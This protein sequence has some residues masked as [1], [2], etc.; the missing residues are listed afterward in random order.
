MRI[1]LAI[2]L[3]GTTIL[4]VLGCT[5]ENSNDQNQ[6]P[7]VGGTGQ[8]GAGAAMSGGGNAG[9]GNASSGSAGV[10]AEGGTA[11]SATGGQSTG[12]SNAGT[13]GNT[14]GNAGSAAGGAA[15]IGGAGTGGMSSCLELELTNF[16]GF[17][18][19][20]IR[21]DISPSLGADSADYFLI[22]LVDGMTGS[23]NLT[24]GDDVNYKTCSH[25]F[26]VFQDVDNA[27]SPSKRF[28]QIS[29]TTEITVADPDLNATSAGSI[30]DLTLIEVT[31]TGGG[32][33]TSTPVEGGSCL[34]VTMGMWDTTQLAL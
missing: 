21:A 6:A 1:I 3:L 4:T 30:N 15:G 19:G 18:D 16:Q 5:D 26:S 8:A 22:E 12:G 11:G 2:T 25:C 14:G 9:T 24:E 10:S 34:H 28:F 17:S 31:I 13:G 27:G 23:F 32:D 33:Y 20:S 29:G 7:G